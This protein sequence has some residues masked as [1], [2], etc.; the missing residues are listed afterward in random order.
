MIMHH[1][2]FEEHC[3]QFQE[4]VWPLRSTTNNPIKHLW[5]TIESLVHAPSPSAAVHAQ[6]WMATE[7]T[8]LNISAGDL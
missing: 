6:L 2:W 8:Q 7:A 4:K 1:N 3:G 5:N